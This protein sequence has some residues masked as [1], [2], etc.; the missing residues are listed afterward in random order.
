L[1]PAFAEKM[2]DLIEDMRME[3]AKALGTGSV[4]R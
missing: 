2:H 1:A 4:R 3:A